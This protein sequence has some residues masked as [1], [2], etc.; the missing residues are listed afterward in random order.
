MPNVLCVYPKFPKT[1]WGSEYSMPL[2]GKR[3][4]LPPL[5]LLTIAALLPPEWPVRLCD[6]NVRPLD[7]ELL[8]WADV[9][10][11]SGMLIQR[12][13]LLEVARRARARGKTTV[14]G[15]PYANTNTTTPL[16]QSQPTAG[17]GGGVANFLATL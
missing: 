11:L 15:G 13:S 1:Y 4:L 2:T 10:F 9:V 17:Q 7:D 5:G 14:A 6:L 3:A 8:D 16:L 12:E